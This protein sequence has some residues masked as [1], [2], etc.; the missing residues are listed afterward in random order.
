MEVGIWAT[1]YI[2]GN[3]HYYYH[4]TKL[5]PDIVSLLM[6]RYAAEEDV[7]KRASAQSIFNFTGSSPFC[8]A[9]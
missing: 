2:P 6:E 3:L 1:W 9:H 7:G 5:H 4:V 8:L